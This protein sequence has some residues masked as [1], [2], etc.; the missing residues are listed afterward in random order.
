MKMGWERILRN[1][2]V[3]F[4]VNFLLE[5]LAEFA[6]RNLNPSRIARPVRMERTPRGAPYR[7]H[8]PLA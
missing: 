7:N 1:I 3:N 5:F 4:L 2:E 8:A 6:R